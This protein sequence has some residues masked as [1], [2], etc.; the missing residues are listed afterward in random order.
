MFGFGRTPLPRD[1]HPFLRIP[2][3]KNPADS[4]APY[5]T[6]TSKAR[7]RELRNEFGNKRHALL[8][9]ESFFRNA[10]DHPASA[11]PW[12][13]YWL[14]IVSGLPSGYFP[15]RT[16]STAVQPAKRFLVQATRGTTVVLEANDRA[17]L[18]RAR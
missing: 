18:V 16:M 5:W 13:H 7:L 17:D 15:M 10:D 14:A 9:R 11:N 6:K 4:P 3:R 12:R 8:A 2:H 1:V